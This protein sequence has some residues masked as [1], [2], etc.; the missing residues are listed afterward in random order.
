M[1]EVFHV[2]VVENP[3]GIA[4]RWFVE[5]RLKDTQDKTYDKAMSAINNDL[6]KVIKHLMNNLPKGT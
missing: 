5:I 3:V 6:S 2:K 1:I 4:E